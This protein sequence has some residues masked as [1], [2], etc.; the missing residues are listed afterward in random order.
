MIVSRPNLVS[1][2]HL[3][4][5]RVIPILARVFLCQFPES[6]CGDLGGTSAT[7]RFRCGVLGHLMRC[8]TEFDNVFTFI[9]FVDALEDVA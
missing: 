6:A 2:Y 3:Q 1:A 9:N 4:V 5:D 8:V 7:I